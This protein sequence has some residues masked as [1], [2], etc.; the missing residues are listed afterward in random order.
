VILPVGPDLFLISLLYFWVLS[1][2]TGF[3]LPITFPAF[4]RS[5]QND[6]MVGFQSILDPQFLLRGIQVDTWLCPN[7]CLI[8][9]LPFL[10]WAHGPTKS[11]A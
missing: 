9:P 6:G 8:L 7:L 3:K 10:R 4:L 2:G 5:D 11:T 1:V